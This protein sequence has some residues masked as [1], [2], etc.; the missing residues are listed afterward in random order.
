L[1]GGPS[2]DR[3]ACAMGQALGSGWALVSAPELVPRWGDRKAPVS[4]LELDSASGFR[5][6]MSSVASSAVELAQA[7]ARMMAAV[8][9]LVWAVESAISK[10]WSWEE[11]SVASS[12]VELAAV[13]GQTK[14]GYLEHYSGC[15]SGW[16]SIS[17]KYLPPLSG[18][19][20]TRQQN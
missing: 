17:L 5:R 2:V 8:T 14:G 16:Q 20:P 7:W 13:S 11:H 10:E 19:S 12:V 9:A 3:L 6:A 15:E 1:L 18:S 4:A